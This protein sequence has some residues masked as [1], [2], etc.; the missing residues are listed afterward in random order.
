VTLECTAIPAG[1]AIACP[2][3]GYDAPDRIDAIPETYEFA[4]SDLMDP[5]PGG[6]LYRC[7]EC[8]L[9]FRYPRLRKDVL[10][11]LYESVR[12][13]VWQS[14]PRGRVDWQ[15]AARTIRMAHDV[16]SVLDVGCFDGRFLEYL[17]HAYI[18]AGIEIH[19]EAAREARRRGVDIVGSDFAHLDC[20]ARKFDCVT[21]ID[22]IEHV[23]NPLSFLKQLVG[24]TRPGGLI[25]LS[26]G[27]PDAWSW[28]V[29]KG[30]YWY[31]GLPEHIAFISPSWCR[32][33]AREIGLTMS[34]LEHF[35][36]EPLP[37]VAASLQA[38][39]NLL[40]RYTPKVAYRLRT[41]YARGQGKPIKP[42]FR[43]APPWRCATDHFIVVF[44]TSRSETTRTPETQAADVPTHSRE[45]DPVMS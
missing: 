2:S 42:S 6:A 12:P 30:M 18:R 40:Y 8:D 15:L 44:R 14:S 3:C 41:L 4:G 22:V 24:V 10:D 28:R 36:H 31:C 32:R 11:K 23:A 26:T 5:L 38:A 29:M 34:P 21:A 37:R 25:L 13:S 43:L 27:N 19:P 45:P 39:A 17:G 1:E 16:R 35:S 20:E 7:G 9:R 33:V